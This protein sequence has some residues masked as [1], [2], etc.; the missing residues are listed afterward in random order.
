MSS[1]SLNSIQTL[2]QSADLPFEV[3]KGRLVVPFPVNEEPALLVISS[4]MNGLVINFELVG[5]IPPQVVSESE[6]LGA[7]LWFITQQ[8]WRTS[9]G[10]CE[11][12]KDGEL[13]VVVEIPLADAEITNNQLKLVFQL[14]RDHGQAMRTAGVAVL[15]TGE[16]PDDSPQARVAETRQQQQI[17]EAIR[18]SFLNMAQTPAGRAELA[19][20]A[21][22]DSGHP[23]EVRALAKHV[24]AQTGPTEL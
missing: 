12:D 5:L 14:L 2:L 11:L 24:L 22:P 18:L 23:A 1:Q 8:N 15:R 7:F 21:N 16:I 9:A 4:Q 10:S 20:I 6:H 17:A 13:R 19:K 3:N